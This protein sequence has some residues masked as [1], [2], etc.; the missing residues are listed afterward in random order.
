MMLSITLPKSL[1]TE[2]KINAIQQGTTM[3]VLVNEILEDAIKHWEKDDIQIKK[4]SIEEPVRT[5]LHLSD[6]VYFNI[7][8]IAMITGHNKVAVVC[9]L[10]MSPIAL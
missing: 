4:I 6:E 8:K 9:S 5:S 3:S 2:F 1:H 10:I 7:D